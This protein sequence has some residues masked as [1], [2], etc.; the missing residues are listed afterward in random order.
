MEAINK[1]KKND[2]YMVDVQNIIIDESFNV[3][4]DYGDIDGLAQSIMAVGQIDAVIG[5]KNHGEETFTLTDGFRRMRAIKKAKEMGADIP[6]VKLMTGAKSMEDRIFS[7]VITGVDKKN[8]TILE[9]AEAYK[10]LVAHGYEIKEIA[11]RVG[12]T[13]AHIGNL[14][15]LADV[16]QKVKNAITKELITGSTVINIIREVKDADEI[17][18][19]VEEAIEKAKEGGVTESGS[20]KKKATVKHLNI[21]K[22]NTPL[23]KLRIAY[24][25]LSDDAKNREQLEDLITALTDKESTPDQI[26]TIFS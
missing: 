18:S 4:K 8:L 17:V 12:K 10:L 25:R 5:F 19:V 3:R 15:K 6:L 22:L 9:E 13:P 20:P 24:E 11:R 2:Y 14:L 23:Q 16:P 7:M 21:A 26:A 1:T